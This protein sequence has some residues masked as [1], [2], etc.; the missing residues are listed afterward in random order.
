MRKS[1]T[2]ITSI[3]AASALAVSL[4]VGQIATQDNIAIDLPNPNA[5]SSPNPTGTPPTP[6]TP[7]PSSSATVTAK[8][9]KSPAPNPAPAEVTMKSDA[10]QYKYGVVQIS[11]TKLGKKLTA[12]SL[13]QGDA[14]NGRDQAYKILIDATLQVQG[15]NFGNVS[16]ATFTTDAFRKAVDNAL[17]KF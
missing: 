2:I 11:V 14:T 5:S 16:G 8:P 17:L 6:P 15:T 3:V 9:T 4:R 10:I 7:G 12:V 1:T 13:L